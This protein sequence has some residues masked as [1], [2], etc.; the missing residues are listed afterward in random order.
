MQ[1]FQVH[2]F[3]TKM[4]KSKI[5]N[6]LATS[7][8]KSVTKELLQKN[9]AETTGAARTN[10]SPYSTMKSALALYMTRK[11]PFLSLATGGQRYIL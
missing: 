4:T 2:L 6:A 8:T 3:N 7:V 11:E 10:A 5:S 1:I 9:K